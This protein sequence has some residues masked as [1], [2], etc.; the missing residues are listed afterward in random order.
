MC[1]ARLRDPVPR[2]VQSS[3][4]QGLSLSLDHDSQKGVCSH[5]HPKKNDFHTKFTFT[6]TLIDRPQFL[7]HEGHVPLNVTITVSTIRTRKSTDLFVFLSSKNKFTN[8]WR[9]DLSKLIVFASSTWP[10]GLK[11]KPLTHGPFAEVPCSRPQKRTTGANL[12]QW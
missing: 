11:H 6:F 2:S 9:E 5:T 1:T 7:K 4:S 12:Y 8:F 10:S 3:V